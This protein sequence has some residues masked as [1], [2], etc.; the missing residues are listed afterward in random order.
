M[1]LGELL[2]TAREEKQISLQEVEKVTKIRTAYLLALE[3]EKFHLLPGRIYAIGFL[4]SYAKFL[5]LSPEEIIGIYKLQ[6]PEKSEEELKKPPSF[7]E[8]P[9]YSGP[10]KKSHYLIVVLAASILIAASFWYQNIKSGDLTNGYQV[11]SGSNE[12]AT[13]PFEDILNDIDGE[14]MQDPFIPTAPL[15]LIIKIGGEDCWVRIVVDGK[16]VMNQTLKPGTMVEFEGNEEIFV[17]FGNPGVAQVYFNGDD[18]GIIG[19]SRQPL[20]KTF[21]KP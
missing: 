10:S 9:V 5:S 7:E 13:N 21:K 6:F 1:R 14:G 2:K 11:I 19:S 4:K 15:S 3:E 16:E 12:E 8:L 18:L 20:Q 17:H